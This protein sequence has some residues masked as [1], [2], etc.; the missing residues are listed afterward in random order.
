[1]LI[2]TFVIL[3]C[4]DYSENLSGGYTYVHEGGGNN[5]IIHEYPAKG[6]E[7]PPTVISFDY[8][9]RFI[10]AKQK[11]DLPQYNF[12][13]KE[14]IY[15][16]GDNVFY[17]WLIIKQEQKVIGPLDSIRFLEQRKKYNVPDKLNLK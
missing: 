6:G 10:I 11:P 17:Y 7:I 5:Y 4:S 12:S 3:G 1:M 13:E 14:Y 9:R 2:S 15:N 16:R 8:N